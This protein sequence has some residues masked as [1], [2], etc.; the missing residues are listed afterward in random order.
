MPL[1]IPNLDDRRWADLVEEA[2]ALIPRVAPQWTDHNAHDPGVTFIELLAWLAEMQLYQLN[3][4]GERH[5]EAFARLAGVRRRQR[6][7]ARVLIRVEGK[8]NV[9]VF[10][11][12]G[13]QLTPVG[14]DDLV[15]E[16]D[17]DLFLTASR[18]QHVVVDDGTTSIDETN[19]NERSGV[20]FLAFGEAAAA[21]A[22]LRLGFDT[23]HPSE[24][25][26]RLTFDVFTDDLVARCDAQEAPASIDID[27]AAFAAPPVEV[28]WE[29]LGVDGWRALEVIGDSTR[30]F[31]TSGA[32]TLPTPPAANRRQGAVWIRSR[33]V[34]GAY[35]IE[36]RL[37]NVAVNVIPC[38]Q[39]ETV[40]DERVATGNGRPDQVHSLARR[41][42]LLPTDV[43][44]TAL[45]SSDVADWP[46][47]MSE[48]R[49]THPALGARLFDLRSASGDGSD[50]EYRRVRELNHDVAGALAALG[51]LLGREAVVVTVDDERW[52]RVESF[53]GSHPASTHFVLDSESGRLL[54][55]NGL[56][57]RI[58][59][60]GEEIRAV[61]YQTSA[62]NKGNVAA[63]QRWRSRTADVT[64][65]TL[66]NVAAAAGGA[67][68]ET[69][70]ELELRG[71][72]ALRRPWRA[73]TQR[74]LERL[75]LAT[76]HVHVARAKAIAN[77]PQPEMLTVVVLPKVRPGRKRPPTHV[78]QAFLAAV[79][80]HLERRRLICDSLS[81]IAPIF[82]E[83]RVSARLRLV[84]GASPTAVLDRA[85]EAL[86][87][88]FRGELDLAR[89][90]AT[91][92]T[93]LAS[94]P[95]PTRWPFGRAVVPSEI[96]A[97][98]DTVKG[99]DTV[100]NVV[101]RAQRGSEIVRPD[102]SGAIPLP[103]VGLVVAAA[104]DVAIDDRPRSG[105]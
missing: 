13:T 30:G 8:L 50:T 80:R 37:R 14:D 58:P 66:R 10:L 33:I 97:V 62:G 22:S 64:G 31:A 27:R 70:A 21:G 35:D 90:A 42:L 75:A 76:P 79:R 78:S 57:G 1:D 83:V 99:V 17:N 47:L 5:R 87:R 103:P 15:F 72:A 91:P 54:F 63:D 41:P 92:E 81:V 38:S 23:F 69:I 39:K 67:D 25:E 73:V 49:R 65:V 44:P 105:P 16:T 2:R 52:Q 29:Y 71:Q 46:R 88:F 86:D 85:R 95:C 20:A 94:S 53:D 104:H 4:V 48:A 3:R 32:V 12:A 101:L 45:V 55:G 60:E 98:L 100:W 82:I 40:R 7:P 77:C 93:V 26:L 96:Y 56:N 34:H 89:V 84:K 36:P 74:D 9:G 43:P 68:P 6:V 11:R 51:P 59:A 28:A 24:Q 61:W 102:G 18:L 19:A